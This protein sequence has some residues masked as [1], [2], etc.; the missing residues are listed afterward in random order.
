VK[1][2]R[3][4]VLALALLLATALG[5]LLAETSYSQLPPLPPAAPVTL[6][7]L[8]LLEGWLAYLVRGRIRGRRQGGRPMH[9]LQIARAAVLAKASSLGGAVVGGAYAGIFVWTFG[10]RGDVATYG[11]DARVAGL[12]AA[13]GIGLVGA[14]L[15]LER[16][17]RTPSPPT[18]DREREDA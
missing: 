2:T 15:L 12:A 1:P 7:L 13:A 8:A 9:A 10:R 3:L 5:Y 11:N 6:A 16:S 17:C 14:A 18:D 4:P